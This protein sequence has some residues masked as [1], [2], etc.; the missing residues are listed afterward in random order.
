MAFETESFRPVTSN[1][2]GLRGLKRKRPSHVGFDLLQ[3]LVRILKFTRAVFVYI[4]VFD[5]V[6]VYL[7][8][9]ISTSM[10]YSIGIGRIRVISI[11]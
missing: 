6:K 4:S 2:C 9:Y 1:V 10:S 3:V 11:V 8:V 7:H 5:L